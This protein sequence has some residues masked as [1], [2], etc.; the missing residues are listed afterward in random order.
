M[1]VVNART[2]TIECD[3]H[4]V[5]KSPEDKEVNRALF[6]K[7]NTL[8]TLILEPIRVILKIGGNLYLSAG[9][10]GGHFPKWPPCSI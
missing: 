8:C 3:T 7:S 5:S 10:G 6:D 1:C 9:G 2:R 4:T